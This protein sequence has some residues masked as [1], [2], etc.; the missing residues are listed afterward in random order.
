MTALNSKVQTES[1]IERQPKKQII[2]QD[3][4][5]ICT[6]AYTETYRELCKLLV[7]DLEVYAPSRTVIIYTD[8]ASD[9]EGFGNVVCYEKPLESIEAYHSRRLTIKKSLETFDFCIYIDSDVRIVEPIDLKFEVQPGLTARSC[10][11]YNNHEKANIAGKEGNKKRIWQYKIFCSMA[12]KM[13]IDPQDSSLI[14]VSEF[15]FIVARDSGREM[16]FLNLWEQLALYAKIRRD[17]KA[18]CKQI[19][20]SSSVTG[21]NI[22]RNEMPGLT[23]FDDRVYLYYR[24]RGAP[25][26]E[27]MER[28]LA[29]QQAI[30]QRKISL[31][32]RGVRKIARVIGYELGWL[33]MCARALKSKDRRFLF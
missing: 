26:V 27:K 3:N 18:P 14:W 24:D 31:V 21:F 22:Q 1:R 29:E 32:N 28:C 2:D 8:K 20:L 30:E 11:S 6:V 12:R 19:A 16:D 13:G 15:M 17:G 10:C 25:M 9:F 4:Y 23:F 33:R 7:R 5:C